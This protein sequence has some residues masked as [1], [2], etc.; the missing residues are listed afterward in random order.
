MEKFVEVIRIIY[1]G[2]SPLNAIHNGRFYYFLTT[3]ENETNLIPMD[4][5]HGQFQ[6]FNGINV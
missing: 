5:V 1:T 4:Y 2:L 6:K 3:I